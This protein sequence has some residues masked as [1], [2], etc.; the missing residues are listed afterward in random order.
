MNQREESKINWEGSRTTESINSGSFQR[1]ADS[2]EK[3]ERPFSDLL[4]E[5]K[6]Y[7]EWYHGESEKNRKLYRRISALKGVITKL[8]KSF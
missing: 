7:E 6:K 5:R 8:K 3:M 1:I 4:S 2:L